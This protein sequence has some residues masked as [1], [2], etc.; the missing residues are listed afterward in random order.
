[1]ISQLRSELF[2]QRTTR[3]A[4]VLLFSML[5]VVVLV[6]SLHV[7]TLK[8]ADLSQAANQPK[9]FGWG[10]TIG[11][12]FAALAGAI[13]ITAE[14]RTGAIRP[15]LLANPDRTRVLA[16]KAIAAASAGLVVGLLAAAAVVVLG[17]AG[18]AMRGINIELNAGDFVQLIAGGAVGAALW[19]VVGTGIGALLRGQV[20]AVVGLCVW[21]LLIETILIGNAPSAGK[22]APGAS[23]GALAGLMPNAQ[24][25]K[26][27]APAVGALLLLGYAAVVALIG[28]IAL[29]RRDVD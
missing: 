16:A 25:T 27:L 9:V 3:T 18:L 29:E 17:S 21:L 7:F 26:L 13:G 19:A 24:S 4:R 1:M 8:T 14:F 2:K 6:V 11:A 20:G 15:T 10:A 28:R 12:L 5:A 23:D 22:F